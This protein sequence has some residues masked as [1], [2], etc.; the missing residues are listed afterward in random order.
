MEQLLKQKKIANV[1]KLF[2]ITTSTSCKLATMLK[3]QKG[4]I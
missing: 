1:G 4:G 3:A 2:S